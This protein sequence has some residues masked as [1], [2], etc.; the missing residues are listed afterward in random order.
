MQNLNTIKKIGALISSNTDRMDFENTLLE[1]LEIFNGEEQ[2]Y[3]LCDDLEIAGII[4]FFHRKFD[5]SILTSPSWEE[6]YVI[7]D[8]RV[9]SLF[10]LKVLVA[11]LLAASR[12][13]VLLLKNTGIASISRLPLGVHPMGDIDLLVRHS[14]LHDVD[15]ILRK[16]HFSRPSTEDLMSPHEFEYTFEDGGEILRVEVQTRPV[17][18]RWLNHEQEPSENDLWKN[19][20]RLTSED[21]NVFVFTPEYALMLVALHTAKHS[22]VRA[23]GFRLHTDVDRIV[24]DN[25]IN[26][27]SFISLVVGHNIKVPVFYSLHLASEF[28]GVD[29]PQRVLEELKPGFIRN[30]LILRSLNKVGFLDPHGRKWS[31]LGY[32]IFVSSLF[33]D[34]S[35]FIKALFPDLRNERYGYAIYSEKYGVF[36]H[37]LRLKDLIFRRKNH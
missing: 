36:A 9:S 27:D 22:Y 30:Y 6:Y 19:A 7:T 12:I 11:E 28:L 23:P 1:L 31:K 16:H 35:Q 5:L 3:L 34:F 21:S 14:D 8:N 37:G 24:F 25:D 29:I 13:D 20:T 33:D 17:S 18:G 15:T 26:W 10:R 4:Y 32:I 2:L